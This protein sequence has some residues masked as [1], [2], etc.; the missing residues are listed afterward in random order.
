MYLYV[1]MC[2][3]M[4][5]YI[6]MT[7]ADLKPDNI[8]FTV[9]GTLKLFD[10]G[11][12]TCVKT[13]SHSSESYKMTGYTGSLRYMAPEVALREPYTEK[14]DVYSFGIML[15]QMARDR[16]PFKGLN[17]AEFMRDVVRGGM[18]PKLD[19]TWPQGFSQL[20]SRC[21]HTDPNERPSFAMIVIDLNK[22]ISDACGASTA[23]KAA[24]P[25][26]KVITK[27]KSE[28]KAGSK[29]DTQ[30]SWF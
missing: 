29:H 3:C 2:I 6:Y 28:N 9:D 12:V 8:G 11:L 21:W 16:L 26:G 5:V 24:A 13:R 10:F 23:G 15:W 19:K 30:S 27:T 4:Y 25:R 17:K 7:T 22:L 1:Y 18:R 20:L 14:V